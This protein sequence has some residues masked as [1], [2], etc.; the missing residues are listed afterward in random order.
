MIKKIHN[1]FLSTIDVIA[2]LSFM[3]GM[4][5]IDGT[6]MQY[7]LMLMLIPACWGALRHYAETRGACE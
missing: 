7:S 6:P 5:S 1:I 4:C 3:I 2:I